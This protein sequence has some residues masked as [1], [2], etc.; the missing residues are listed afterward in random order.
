M[1]DS[2]S[3]LSRTPFGDHERL[4]WLA[5]EAGLIA[6]I[7]IFVVYCLTKFQFA[8]LLTDQGRH[9]DFQMWYLLPPQIRAISYPTVITGTSIIVFPYFPSAVAMML[10]LSWL[11]QP[12]S[13]ALW[14]IL[15]CVSL[16]VILWV[17][18]DIGGIARSRI[19]MPVAAA[20]VFIV[21]SPLQ[22]DL[23]GHN[24]NLIYVA[25][26]MLA[27]ASRRTW[28]SAILFAATANLKIYSGVL[29]AGFLWLREYRLAASMALAGLLI[30][31][32]LPLLAFGYDHFVELLPVWLDQIRFTLAPDTIAPLSIRRTATALFGESNAS[33]LT[34][35]VVSTQI[36]WIGLVIAYFAVAAKPAAP[37]S[38]SKV[39]RLCDVIVLLLLP[40][41]LSSWFVPY[42]ALVML[43]AF[44]L[45]L[46]HLADEAAPRRVRV[47]AAIAAAGS[48]LIHLTIRDWE[49]RAGV[50][51][52][53]F[54]MV[55][56]ALGA[57][58]LS[59]ARRAIPI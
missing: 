53:D 11:P 58:R 15:Q 16:V 56:L 4:R 20:A 44:V 29:V 50:Y 5:L 25:L 2:S 3:A 19:R 30:A 42:H 49:L 37:G 39:A 36:A 26:I 28:I 43:P 55:V 54:V 45:I 31:I 8:T 46:A 10:P 33:V 41:P 17:S 51:L 59:L 32:G 38:G 1:N 23:R 52:V 7:A 57:I 27:L 9:G 47:L 14:M 22:W 48:V 40:L 21:S 18:L 13:F 34:A 35:V 6:G 24:N 12:A